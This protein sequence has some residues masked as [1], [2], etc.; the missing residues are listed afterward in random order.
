MEPRLGLRGLARAAHT[1]L[2]FHLEE[3]TRTTATKQQREADGGQRRH[4]GRSQSKGGIDVHARRLEGHETD[5]GQHARH[6]RQGQHVAGQPRHERHDTKLDQHHPLQAVGVGA[7]HPM[8]RNFTTPLLEGEHQAVNEHGEGEDDDGDHDDVIE[9]LNEPEEDVQETDRATDDVDVHQRDAGIG[10]VALAH[11]AL[12]VVQPLGR[13]R[14]RR[15][16]ERGPVHGHR[17]VDVI[18]VHQGLTLCL[19]QHVEVEDES[20]GRNR[21]VG[22]RRFFVDAGHGEVVDGHQHAAVDHAVLAR[23]DVAALAIGLSDAAFDREVAVHDH[24]E[25]Q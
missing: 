12:H 14:R 1:F 22:Q 3:A 21:W 18:V 16:G 20:V 5:R 13:I 6:G 25:S 8:D 2:D 17:E 19:L 23:L 15:G 11:A 9:G 4:D 7:D 10:V 24:R